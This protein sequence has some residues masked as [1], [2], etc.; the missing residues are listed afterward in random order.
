MPTQDILYIVLGVAFFVYCFLYGPILGSGTVFPFIAKSDQDKKAVLN[1]VAPFWD[2]AGVWLIAAAVVMWGAFP[3]AYATLFGGFFLA[4][5]IVLVS[6]ILSV[7]A[8]EL[9]LKDEAR[10]NFWANSYF[11]GNLIPSLLFGVALG[12]V[13]MGIPLN[14][15]LWYSGNFFTLLRPYALLVGLL[16]LSLLVVHAMGYILIK[17]EGEVVQ[18][19]KNM[20]NLFNSIFIALFII[21]VFWTHHMFK[22]L[23]IFYWIVSAVIVILSV[24]LMIIKNYQFWISTAI[25]LFSWIL[26]GLIQYPFVIRGLENTGIMLSNSSSSVTQTAMIVIIAVGLP[27]VALYTYYSY[28]V[29]RGKF[30]GKEQLY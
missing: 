23:S 9:Y 19:A 10:K 7:A 8:I 11:V 28:F 1:S 2:G 17:V 29:F 24:I 12:N 3:Q 5:F 13:I 25:L 4:L 14:Q 22:D 30:S 18:K 27:F 15:D 20:L 26:V 21:F 16:G 6:I